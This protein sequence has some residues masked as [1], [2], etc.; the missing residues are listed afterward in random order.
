MKLEGYEGNPIGA[1]E[2]GNIKARAITRSEMND[3]SAQGK[4]FA[5]SST[6]TTAG[7]ESVLY[8]KNTSASSNMELHSIIL[9]SSA[10]TI[11]TLY[12]ATGTAAGTAITGANLNLGSTKSAEA[13]SYGNAA[14]TGLTNGNVL[15]RIR[16]L[17]N[18]SDRFDFEGSIIVPPNTAVVLGVSALIT[19]EATIYGHFNSLETK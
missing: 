18:Y 1:D 17:A 13:S 4:A 14:V 12:Q 19:F 9:G 15:S 7:A 11:F 2:W 6:Y 16:I 10:N 8:I 3:A 5:W